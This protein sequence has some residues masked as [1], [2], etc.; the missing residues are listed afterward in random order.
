[1]GAAIAGVGAQ[2]W[3]GGYEQRFMKPAQA[4]MELTE[5]ETATKI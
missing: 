1:M 4:C 5:R 3:M 2:R